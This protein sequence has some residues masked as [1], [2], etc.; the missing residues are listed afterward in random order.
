VGEQG[1]R[2]DQR[3]RR[4]AAPQLAQHVHGV[5]QTATRPAETPRHGER[6][7]AG[8]VRAGHPVGGER[9]VAVVSGRVAR[10]RGDEIG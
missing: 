2:G 10:Q 3:H 1:H 7:Q 8:G 5:G 6:E 9:A 4:V